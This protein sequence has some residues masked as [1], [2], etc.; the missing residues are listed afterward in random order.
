MKA[1]CNDVSRAKFSTCKQSNAHENISLVGYVAVAANILITPNSFSLRPE[2]NVAKRTYIKL[3]ANGVGVVDG[4]SEE[5]DRNGAQ[6]LWACSKFTDNL[7]I[8]QVVAPYYEWNWCMC[9]HRPGSL[10][11]DHPVHRQTYLT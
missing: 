4:L 11:A 2:K 5:F 10:V 6:Q 9:V 3:Y 8:L 1:M 7:Y